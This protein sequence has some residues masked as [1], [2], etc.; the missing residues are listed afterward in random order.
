[1]RFC[2]ENRTIPIDYWYGNYGKLYRRN[3]KALTKTILK[4]SAIM[5]WKEL[6]CS[7]ERYLFVEKNNPV[8]EML[9]KINLLGLAKEIVQTNYDKDLLNQDATE[10]SKALKIDSARLKRL[11]NMTPT[12]ITLKWMQYEKM[13]NTIWP[14]CMIP[15]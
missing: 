12:T 14:D 1:M 8:I 2:K 10:L 11:K 13:A 3:L 15:E 5:L 7:S 9:A 4:N 6:P